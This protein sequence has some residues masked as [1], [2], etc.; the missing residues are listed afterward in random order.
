MVFCCMTEQSTGQTIISGGN[1]SGKWEKS[2][3]PF[4]IKGNIVIPLGLKLKI[5]PGVEI[6]FQGHHKFEINGALE[7]LGTASELIHFTVADTLGWSD[8]Y[9][10]TGGWGGLIFQNQSA[11]SSKIVY[12]KFEYGK[13][14]GN[15]WE[16]DNAGGAIFID[17]VSNIVVRNSIFTHN[18]AKWNG[19]AIDCEDANPLF[20]NLLIYNNKAERSGGAISVDSH[21]ISTPTLINLTI[22]GNKAKDGSAISCGWGCSPK[23]YNTIIWHNPA[24]SGSQ[25]FL[26]ED[27]ADPDFTNCIIDGGKEAFAGIGASLNYK[28]RYLNCLAIDPLFDAET[29]N[30]YHLKANSYC[31]NTGT[32]N[33]KFK[34]CTLDLMGN[35]RIHGDSIDI[36]AYEAPE[37]P[38]NRLPVIKKLDNMQTKVG[39]PLD[40]SISYIDPD[41]PDSHTI[42]VVSDNANM[43]VVKNGDTAN[44]AVYTLA[45]K[46]NWRGK[47]KISVV[48]KDSENRI[49][50]QNSSSFY[51]TVSNTIQTGGNIL[52]N[53]VWDADTMAIVS[54]IIVRDNVM[55]RIAKGTVVQF[56]GNYKINVQGALSALGEKNDSIQFC[57]K[58]AGSYWAGILISGKMADMSN[59]DS[60]KF[61]HC[62]IT[63]VNIPN[64]SYVGAIYMS[65]FSKVLISRCRI[66]NTITGG[67]GAI[68]CYQNSNPR[69]ENNLIEYTQ[70]GSGIYCNGSSP[71]I[72]NNK[73]LYNGY[74]QPQMYGGGIYLS[75]SSPR[76]IGNLIAYNNSYHTGAGIYC[77][78]SSN[79]LII[80]N[81]ICY[82]KTTDTSLAMGGG[83]EIYLNSSP[84]ITNCILWGN[85][86]PKTANQLNIY[87]DD[88]LPKIT[89]CNIQGGYEE[90]I[91]RSESGKNLYF[92]GLYERNLA[93]DP[94]FT[95]PLKLDFS[96]KSI[97]PCVDQC[98]AD[99]SNLQLPVYDLLGNPRIANNLVDMGAIEFQGV[100]LNNKPVI[101]K[102][103]S[104]NSLVSTPVKM[105]VIF[106]DLD[107]NDTHIITV[108]SDNANV[109]IQNLSGNTSGSTYQ[110]VPLSGWTGSANITVKVTDNRGLENSTDINTYP[111]TITKSACGMISG[112]TVWPKGKVMVDCNV[113]VAENTTLTIQA[114]T[115]VEFQNFCRLDVYGKILALGKEK[116][117]IIFTV[118]DT[119]GYAYSHHHK[120]WNG[121]RFYNNTGDT[122]VITYTKL[123]YGKAAVGT[124][125]E[126][127]NNGGAINISNYKNIR[128]TNSVFKY[129]YAYGYGSA[130]YSLGASPLIQNC[131]FMNNWSDK[132]ATISVG[133]NSKILNN[134]IAYNTAASGGGGIYCA[135]STLIDGN[136]I[137]NNVINGDACKGGGIYCGGGHPTITNNIIA[138]NSENEQYHIGV[139]GG[140]Y[141]TDCYPKKF[142]N[143]IIYNN[144]SDRGSAVS[145]WNSSMTFENSIINGSFECA[146]GYPTFINCNLNSKDEDKRKMTGTGC[147]YADPGF[148]SPTLGVGI[149]FD[150]LHAVW[151]LLST[152]YCIN[153]GNP[154][155]KPVPG[156]LDIAGNPRIYGGTVDMG[157]YEFQSK[158]ANRKPVIITIEDKTMVQ[159][160][161]MSL[162]VKFWDPD[163]DDSHHMAVSSNNSH[164]AV[165]QLSGDTSGSTFSLVSVDPWIGTAQISIK[166]SDNSKSPDSLAVSTFNVTVSDQVCGNISNNIV[167]SGKV[168]VACPVTIED[169]ITLKI[170]PGTIIEFA[171]DA[172]L[173]VV[174]TLIAQGNERDSILFT[175]SIKAD[176]WNGISFKNGFYAYGHPSGVMNDNDTSKFDFCKFSDCTT[177]ALFID[178]YSKVVVSNSRF[179]NNKMSSIRTYEGSPSIL[180]NTFENN[181]A[182]IYEG[183]TIWI[184]RFSNPIITGNVIRYNEATYGGGI[185]CD[186]NCNPR[187][188]NN[189]IYGN[190]ARQGGAIYCTQSSPKLYNN[191]IVNNSAEMGGGIAC[192]YSRP[193]IIN[194]IVWNNKATTQ[195]GQIYHNEYSPL[196]SNCLVQ[197]DDSYKVDANENLKMVFS[198]PPNF[199]DEA[200]NNFSLSAT[201]PCINTGNNKIIDESF[202]VK[203]L[204]GNNRLSDSIIDLGAI[205]FKGIPENIAPVAIQLSSNRIDENKPAGTVVGILKTIDPNYNDLHVFSL[206]NDQSGNYSNDLFVISGDTLKTKSS[207]DYESAATQVIN[208]QVSDN[209][210]KTLIQNLIIN[211][212]NVNE[213]PVVLHP[214]PDLYIKINSPFSY[215]IPSNT[216][217]KDDGEYMNFSANLVNTVKLPDW[218]RMN[219]WEPSFYG[220]PFDYGT[221]SIVL[222]ASDY[223]YSQTDTFNITIV[224]DV[225]KLPTVLDFKSNENLA[226]IVLPNNLIEV[227]GKEGNLN[228]EV[229]LQSGEPLPQGLS[230]NP[231]DF[232]FT[233]D[234]NNF[235]RDKSSL[236]VQFDVIIAVTD[237]S[238]EKTIIYLTL[239]YDEFLASIVQINDSEINAVIYPNPNSGRFKLKLSGINPG[240]YQVC[241][242]TLEGKQ[243]YNHLLSSISDNDTHQFN[244]EGL[245]RGIYFISISSGDTKI[246]RKLVIN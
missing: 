105:K 123:I 22:T 194:S 132:T 142:S 113:T 84:E 150:A 239:K 99:T 53:T 112:N 57:S 243:V 238:G 25:I 214:I 24:T 160:S 198:L 183:G 8:T 115:T 143:N 174:G 165:Q 119:T 217:F 39:V 15:G 7:A 233:L 138:N 35:N 71:W 159:L 76:M 180:N 62:I 127:E 110:V 121:I 222:K 44:P 60:T 90:I 75:N 227:I 200:R 234:K 212:F 241:L 93:L 95:N 231:K 242:Y 36:G 146:W 140:I 240:N 201:S 28:G 14:T 175:P 205:E 100:F 137:C 72:V 244:L 67:T 145:M 55:L 81:T 98:K 43:S 202:P 33:S 131:N 172:S 45:P 141:F 111:V 215:L 30:N 59:N 9:S 167:W 166:V 106:S 6:V 79:P 118:K 168:K 236:A 102:I 87:Y 96:L 156:E 237:I 206:A 169:N 61:V 125:Y 164:I 128:I 176:G 47:V 42:E 89:Y 151:S 158:P 56:Q 38:V 246:V 153:T 120:G 211:I 195:G 17:G 40:V 83:V 193:E 16:V 27:T 209:G 77:Y 4:L 50:D 104:L 2:N 49:S 218:L 63:G 179:S 107:K 124:G 225:I 235:Q 162:A 114:G 228:P 147:V 70:N 189:L 92:K 149:K 203:D 199:M 12:C 116:D 182:T 177:I 190:K 65:V 161:Q 122:S 184:E 1:V 196:F 188:I 130:I 66:S 108:I 48:V 29:Q 54:D 91:I 171:K 23:I 207:L 69:I 94:E 223:W 82:N 58:G 85:S 224:K 192:Y 186:Y 157:P 126:L 78:S 170:T 204:Y 136:R 80:N 20:E 109:K 173:E 74:K 88:C 134:I 19:G 208:V 51:V 26:S 226:N 129:N 135:D 197:S 86:N 64:N 232:S 73:I 97:S 68:V 210:G 3:S 21:Y 18:W 213:P 245:N 41:S 31:I 187:I 52:Q 230:F 117:T 163:P 144:I 133:K 219:T 191:T 46:A 103:S 155:Y 221:Y 34:N 154:N 152:S 37:A 229:F 220:N 178:G 139:G 181:K 101:Q 13:K 10:N 5:D 148:F 32:L 185:K 216:F 11:D